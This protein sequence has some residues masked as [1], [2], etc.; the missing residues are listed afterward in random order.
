MWPVRKAV[1]GRTG[2][3]GG[4]KLQW[5]APFSFQRKD[6]K[7]QGGQGASKHWEDWSCL[8]SEA[9]ILMDPQACAV[10]QGIKERHDIVASLRLRVG[11]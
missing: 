10:A 6:A 1:A 2:A 5:P 11:N 3:T 8:R 7:T 4:A 9:A